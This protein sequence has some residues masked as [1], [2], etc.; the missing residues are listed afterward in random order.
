VS[1]SIYLVLPD[2]HGDI[3]DVHDSVVDALLHG[4]RYIKVA[5]EL[6]RLANQEEQA[7]KIKTVLK[8]AYQNDSTGFSPILN[9]ADI[10]EFYDLLQGLEEALKQSIIDSKSMILPERLAEVRRRTTLLHL[11]EDR[12]RLAVYGIAEGLSQVCEL[13]DFLKQ[14][15]DQNLHVALG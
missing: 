7:A 6:W 5:L 8:R 10:K 4:P 12:G 1:S 3:E 9:T 2:W 13:E 15:L 14:A 11:D